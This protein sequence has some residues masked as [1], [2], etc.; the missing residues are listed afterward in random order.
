L[1]RL[2]CII[3]D[4]PTNYDSDLFIKII[5]SL[6]S[7]SKFKYDSYAYFNR[8]LS[9]LEINKNFKIITDHIKANVFAIADGALPSNKDRGSVLRR[10]IRRSMVC[11]RKL[12]MS[13]DFIIVCATSIINT[14]KEIFNNLDT[15]KEIIIS[16]LES[17]RMLF[18]NT[19][20]VGYK[21]FESKIAGKNTLDGETT[22]KLVDTYGFP[23]ELIK[24]LCEQNNI[25]VDVNE[26]FNRLQKHKEIS[27]ANISVGMETQKIDLLEF[28][29]VSEFLYDKQELDNVKIIAM[30]NESFNKK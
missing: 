28:T 9:Q 15:N 11:A 12:Q 20:E 19:I 22:F 7:I 14:Y 23:F 4:V 1:E 27:K 2:A 16:V 17:E 25:N 18:D 21:L 24:E 30:F 26:F 6:E 13:S 3:Q 10:L 29:D 8:D 5:H